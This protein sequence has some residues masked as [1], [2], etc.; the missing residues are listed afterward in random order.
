MGMSGGKMVMFQLSGKATPSS[1]AV[2]RQTEKLKQTDIIGSGGY[3]KVY[4]L[5]LPDNTAFAV[6]KL[7]RG[8]K[9]RERGFERE[10]ET[11]ADI[12]HRNLVS[13]RGY[14]SAPHINILI[15]DLMTQGNLDTLLHGN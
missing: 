4:K 2:L 5:V 12:K 6:K 9:D 13:L 10:L 11:L 8:S 3:G 7:E 14:Y 1:K 15:Y